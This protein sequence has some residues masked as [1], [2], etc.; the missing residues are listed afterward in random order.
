M[1]LGNV[2]SNLTSPSWNSQAETVALT[3]AN[4]Y[5]VIDHSIDSTK[6]NW[7]TT[8]SLNKCRNNLKKRIRR[9]IR[10]YSNLDCS[11]EKEA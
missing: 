8:R 10:T 3:T 5:K 4:H 9:S 11:Q 1:R 7:S 2:P 6:T